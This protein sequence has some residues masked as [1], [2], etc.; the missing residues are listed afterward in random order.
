MAPKNLFA[1]QQ[2]RNRHGEQ[3]FGHGESGGE[4]ETCGESSMEASITVCKLESQRE[5]ELKQGL[6]T[7]LGEGDGAGDGRGVQKGGHVCRP[8][9]DPC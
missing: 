1:G 9:A 7:N 8:T 5:W 6:C 3:T 2:W 4:G